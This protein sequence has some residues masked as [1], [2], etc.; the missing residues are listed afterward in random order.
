MAETSGFA[1]DL[2]Q[3]AYL[4]HTIRRAISAAEQRSHRYVTLEHLLLALLDDPDAQALLESARADLPGLRGATTETVNHNLAT[5]YTP[6]E[7]DLRASYKVER[8]LQ[9]A[10]DDARRMGCTEVDGAFVAVALFH[11]TDSPAYDLLKRHNFVFHAANGWLDR[12]RGRRSAQFAPEPVAEEETAEAQPTPSAAQKA[13]ADEAEILLEDIVEDSEPAPPKRVP[14]SRQADAAA[15]S[16]S[17]KTI[18]PVQW[19]VVR[20][21][22]KLPPNRGEGDNLWSRSGSPLRPIT[23]RPTADSAPPVRQEPELGTASPRD[24][25]P[26][27][28]WEIGPA[29]P[30]PTLD[31][32]QMERDWYGRDEASRAEPRFATPAEPPRE[33][34]LTP[35]GRVQPVPSGGADVRPIG[36][37]PLS[38]DPDL[39]PALEVPATAG[40]PGDSA[41]GRA[42]RPHAS[43]RERS[44][45]TSRSVLPAPT[46]EAEAPPPANGAASP[47]RYA[48]RG[49]PRAMPVPPAPRGE[50][51]VPPVTRLDN[52]RVRPAPA[53]PAPQPAKPLSKKQ[54]AREREAEKAAR[55]RPRQS[56]AGT[57]YAG[58]LAENIP[59]KMRAHIRMPVEVRVSRDE[60]EAFLSGFEG[61]A[62]LFRH[63]I[64]VTQAMSVMLRAP[65]GGF[66]IESLGPETQWIFT[67]PGFDKEP[68]GRWVWSVTPTETGRRRLQLVVAARS[69]DENGL[70][71]DTAMPEQ[72]ITVEVRANYTR[73][74]VQALKWLAL[75]ALG[76]VVTEGTVLILKAL[77]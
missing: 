71:G 63:S 22:L 61:N 15:Q 49:E 51:P 31:R 34:D 1:T 32:S 3:S 73:G 75:M 5:L 64:T 23:S 47:R 36:E 13:P 59:R 66:T 33:R 77:G 11:E 48:E 38:V 39:S 30:R 44:A 28:S 26:S 41:D 4:A 37:P 25:S 52:M 72:V 7:F 62:E 53:P 35:A 68:F 19:P 70:A 46:R 16:P 56:S 76:G 60:T 65:D 12:N 54:A 69:V 67:R 10:S 8:V 55:G 43:A 6:G 29:V 50:A 20:P 2:P 14:R 74:A 18:E 58:K 27:P 17:G 21:S 42:S 24:P 57:A 40:R 9:S 45:T